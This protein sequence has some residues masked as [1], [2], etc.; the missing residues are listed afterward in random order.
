[1]SSPFQVDFQLDTTLDPS[2]KELLHRI[3]PLCKHY[4]RVV[5]YAEDQIQP[6]SGRVN[7]VPISKSNVIIPHN[8]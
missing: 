3:L 2:L 1:M 5:R 8:K 6:G 4:S 7:Q